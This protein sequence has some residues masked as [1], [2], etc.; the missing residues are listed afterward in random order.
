MKSFL[1]PIGGSDTDGPLFETA[2]TAARPYSSHLQFLHV[3]VGAGEAAANIPHTEFA[4]GPALSNAL[5]EL[6]TKAQARSAVAAQHFR[7]FCE[8]SM[9][10]ICDAPD[11]SRGVT[12]SWHEED[13]HALKRI[14]LRARHND[15]V[16]V[17][18]A[19]KANGLP[20]DFIERLL[21]GCGRPVLIANSTPPPTLTGT[22]M[23]CWKE[24]AEAARAVSA[25]MPFLTNARRVVIVSVAENDEDIAEAM[26]DVARQFAWNG[27]HAETRVITP[28]G[29]AVPGLLSAAAQA[30]GADLVVLGAY[31]RSRMREVLFGSCTESV[32]RNADR[33]ALLMH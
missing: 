21:I 24:T 4:F 23:V 31:G 9:I 17:G 8:R 33:P 13:G 19:K 3:H 18:R 28:D 15:L 26:G 2:L 22:I 14:I 5:G 30:C 20:A 25:A 29:G 11:R 10:E 27:I 32:I 12:A 16:V 1:I 7:D 6:D